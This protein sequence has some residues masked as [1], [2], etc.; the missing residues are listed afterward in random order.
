M[1]IVAA[2]LG[3]ESAVSESA[4]QHRARVGCYLAPVGHRIT[5]DLYIQ[6]LNELTVEALLTHSSD[7]P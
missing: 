6:S 4:G 3:S 5:Q 7:N 1:P 2:E